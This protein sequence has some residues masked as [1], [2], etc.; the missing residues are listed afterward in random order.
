MDH[1]NKMILVPHELFGKD[2]SLTKHMSNL[3]SAMLKVTN[4][5]SLPIDAKIVQYNKILR[6]YRIAKQK[7][8]QPVKIEIHEPFETEIIETETNKTNITEAGSS[9]VFED[10]ILDTVPQK[11]HKKARLLLK[12]TRN[13]PNIKWTDKGEMIVDGNKIVGSNI[14]DIIND[15]S[16]DRKSDAVIGS[17]VLL[18]KLVEQN[19]PK[20]VIVNK[21]RLSLLNDE[22]Y[23]ATPRNE[24]E[25]SKSTMKS[26][27]IQRTTSALTNWTSFLG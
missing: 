17:E 25:P 23:A 15:L 2:E 9:N 21:K 6:L 1:T 8:E 16:R 24:P 22:L 5:E 7:M 14:V 4:D 11:S 18:K 19:V 20:E 12:Y 27:S 26:P 10:L 13:N 3:D